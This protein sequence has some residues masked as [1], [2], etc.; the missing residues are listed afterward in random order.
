MTCWPCW[1]GEIS[2]KEKRFLEFLAAWSSGIT[3]VP[4]ICLRKF[5]PSTASIYTL[6]HR[7]QLIGEI[8][9]HFDSTLEGSSR[10]NQSCSKQGQGA[11]VRTKA[12]PQLQHQT[13]KRRR[14]RC[15]LPPAPGVPKPTRTKALLAYRHS[16]SPRYPARREA[17]TL[18]TPFCVTSR[19]SLSTSP[20]L[21]ETPTLRNPLRKPPQP[22]H[23]PYLRLALWAAPPRTP[24]GLSH[25]PTTTQ[26]AVGTTG[27]GAAWPRLSA[28]RLAN[29]LR[30]WVR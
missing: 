16:A 24:H 5:W 30:G 14:T 25:V 28:A 8:H 27:R 20:R 15:L 17:K 7:R 9:F 18:F 21:R 26:P 29:R 23:R 22:R 19:F 3:A 13:L 12:Q 1:H 6:W 10:R 2:F 4:V 11:Q